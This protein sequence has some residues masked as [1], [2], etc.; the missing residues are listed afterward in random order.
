MTELRF[1]RSLYAGEAVDEAIQRFAAHAT[2]E[3]EATDD[4]W[5]LRVTA[6]REA[7]QRRVCGELRNHALALTVARGGPS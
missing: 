7:Q 6:K 4:Y 1:A 5:I 2:V 3:R